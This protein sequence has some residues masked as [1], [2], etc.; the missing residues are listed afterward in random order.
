MQ[1]FGEKYGDWVRV[2]Q[3]GGKPTSLDGYSMEL[4]GGA[5]VRATGGIGLFGV[6]AGGG[7]RGASRRI[8]A[9]PGLED[10]KKANEELRL[11][12]SLSGIVNAPIGELEKKIESLLAQQ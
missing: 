3:I 2:V 6:V 11:I 1:F 10:Y 8:E 9:V 12:K 7:V 4:C 5:H